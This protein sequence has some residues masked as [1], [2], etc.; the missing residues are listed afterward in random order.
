MIVTR[1]RP[2]H[3]ATLRL[4][5]SQS[6]FTQYLTDLEYGKA[7]DNGWSFTGM[8]G[9]RVIGCAGVTE[10][11]PNRGMA[12]ALLAADAGRHF[13]SIHRAVEGFLKASPWRRI[14]AS[15]DVD[16]QEGQRW[17]RLLGF[18]HEGRLRAYTPDGRDNDLFSRVK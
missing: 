15:V 8:V 11:W 4:Q 9:S 3:L 17:I 13:L 2:E 18:E 7:L 10:I 6:G 16:F 14:E 12:W 5:P 1:F